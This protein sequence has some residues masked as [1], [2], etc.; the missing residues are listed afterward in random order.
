MIDNCETRS[1]ESWEYCRVCSLQN[2]L[3]PTENR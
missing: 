1:D 2:Q 3:I